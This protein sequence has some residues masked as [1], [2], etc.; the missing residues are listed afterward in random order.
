[1]KIGATKSG[2]CFSL[3]QASRPTSA[4]GRLENI[5]TSG[6]TKSQGTVDSTST[7]GIEATRRYGRVG[8]S[9][10][11]KLNT[12][13]ATTAASPKFAELKRA[14]SGSRSRKCGKY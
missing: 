8:L 12:H 14:F 3:T 7:T 4:M 2:T 6:T 1:M 10:T 13:A 5:A 9:T 11:I